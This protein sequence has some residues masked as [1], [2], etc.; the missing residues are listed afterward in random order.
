MEIDD[1]PIKLKPPFMGDF[2][3]LV[4]SSKLTGWWNIYGISMEYL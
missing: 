3:L 1:F 2:P 4:A